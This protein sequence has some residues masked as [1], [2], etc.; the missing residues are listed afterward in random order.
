MVQ[1]VGSSVNFKELDR[2]IFDEHNKLRANPRSYIPYLQEMLGHFDGDVYRKPG[3]PMERTHEGQAAVNE[4]IEFLNS[5]EPKSSF[6]LSDGL[7][8]SAYDAVH[9]IGPDGGH[10]KNNLSDGQE[11]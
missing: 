2:K 9:D 3:K 6:E 5:T 11:I 4:A 8:Y 7:G 1:S 10:H